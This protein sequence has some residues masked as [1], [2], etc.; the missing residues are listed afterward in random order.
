M[1]RNYFCILFMLMPMI[2]PISIM[3]ANNQTNIRP[4]QIATPI[5]IIHSL[6]IPLTLK[7][8]IFSEI[9]LNLFANR[10]ILLLR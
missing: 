5:N 3:A 8:W 4:Y 6:N 10:F 2:M 9:I 1:N 7:L